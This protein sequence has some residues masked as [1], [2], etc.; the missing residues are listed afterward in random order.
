MDTVQELLDR[1]RDERE[2]IEERLGQLSQELVGLGFTPP[3]PLHHVRAYLSQDSIRTVMYPEASI[4]TPRLLIENPGHGPREA[5]AV[6]GPREGE[7]TNIKRTRV[8]KA[9]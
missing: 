1:L 9:P 2:S 3:L 6:P 5:T 8:N 7:M 4:H